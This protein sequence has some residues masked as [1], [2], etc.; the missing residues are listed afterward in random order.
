[1]KKFVVSGL[2]ALSVLAG[3]STPSFAMM[4]TEAAKAECMAR[5]NLSEAECSCIATEAGKYLTGGEVMTLIKINN[6]EKNDVLSTARDQSI[7]LIGGAKVY[8]FAKYIVP[9]CVVLK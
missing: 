2:L 4:H 6:G 3:A 9:A 5:G 1:M 8:L 7:G